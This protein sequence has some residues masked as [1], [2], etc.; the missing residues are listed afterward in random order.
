MA[1]YIEVAEARAM[2]GLRVVLMAG[3]PS[4]WSEALKGILH[5]KRLPYVR[6]RQVLGGTNEE[7]RQWTAQSGAPVAVWND[8]RPRITWVEQL[9]LAEELRPEPALIPP[10]PEDRALLIGLCHE[11]C[12]EMG[13]GWCLRLMALHA[14][15]EGHAVSSDFIRMLQTKY[16]YSPV[17]AIAAPERVADILRM[18][19]VRLRAQRQ[20]GNR[21]FMGPQLTALDVYWAAFAGMLRALPPDLCP[22]DEQLRQTYT[23]TNPVV[24]AALTPLL[25]EHRDAVYRDYLELPVEL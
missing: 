8:E 13:L 18:L 14:A 17:R 3:V 6:V 5:V 23:N 2:S 22:M 24:Q 16:G 4:P 21:F 7:L 12:G 9:L 25:F 11:I 19:D 20:L 1:N 10:A 15:G